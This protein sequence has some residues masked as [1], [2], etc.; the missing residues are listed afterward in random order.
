[1]T[2]N[3]A[4]LDAGF[5]LLHGCPREGHDTNSEGPEIRLDIDLVPFIRLVPS[6]VPEL[7]CNHVRFAD[8]VHTA[9]SHCQVHSTQLLPGFFSCLPVLVLVL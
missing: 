8:S 4:L 6:F 2:G 5:Q 1:M 7:V 3:H 9:C